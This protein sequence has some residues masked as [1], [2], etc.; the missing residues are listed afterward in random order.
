MYRDMEMPCPCSECGEWFDLNDGYPDEAGDSNTIICEDCHIK[1]EES[2]IEIG[3]LKKGDKFIFKGDK[4]TV[5][6][7]YTKKNEC[8]F[9]ETDFGTS[10]KFYYEYDEVFLIK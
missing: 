9:A 4:Y 1:Q 5:S 10:E 6:M 7:R 3:E 2:K 8:L